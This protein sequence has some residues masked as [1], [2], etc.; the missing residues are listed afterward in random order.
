MRSYQSTNFQYKA[1]LD[2]HQVTLIMTFAESCWSTECLPE[3]VQFLQTHQPSVLKTT[4]FND[5][6]LAFT[7][8]VRHTEIAHLF[9]HLVLDQLCQIKSETIDAEFEG[10]TEWNWWKYPVGSFKVTLKVSDQDRCYLEPALKKSVVV[11]EDLFK[12]TQIK[13]PH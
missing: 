7:E 8:E 3:T 9:E 2:S 6:H 13:K 12:T 10:F 1:H 11:L 4:C 5:D